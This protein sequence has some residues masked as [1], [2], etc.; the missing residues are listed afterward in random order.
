VVDV[1]DRAHVHVRLVADEFL[2]AHD[3]VSLF[4]IG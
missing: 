1:A 4:R 2:L 3:R